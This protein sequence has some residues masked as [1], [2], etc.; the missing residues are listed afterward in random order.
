MKRKP[1]K[2][3]VKENKRKLGKS[4]EER[5]QEIETRK[6]FGNWEI[7]TVIPKKNKEEASLITWTIVK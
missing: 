4:I 1:A 7:D 6:T 5:P 2:K 3:R